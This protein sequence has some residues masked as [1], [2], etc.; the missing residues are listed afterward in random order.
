MSMRLRLPERHIQ[1]PEPALGVPIGLAIGGAA[2]LAF[3]VILSV[4]LGVDLSPW[5]WYLARG[6]GITLYLLSAFLLLSGL[7][8]RAHAFR[9]SIST[10]LLA[11][12]HA[13][14]WQLFLGFLV[15]HVGALMIDPTMTFAA[16]TLL[17]PFRSPA[18]EPWT[19]FGI[20]AA[21]LMIVTGSSSLL[22]R[23]IGYRGWKALHWLS[24]PAFATGLAHGIGA[25][26]DTTQ[27]PVFAMYVVTGGWV[28]AIGMLRAVRHNDRNNARINRLPDPANVRPEAP[29]AR[30]D[31]RR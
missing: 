16:G 6:S 1:R 28:I 9:G 17:V 14:A 5:T 18:A 8:G 2:G 23:L 20:I 27:W 25:G 21:E 31:Y 3:A 10:G 7:G 11:S 19:G 13:Y 12:L 22:R 24:L 15:L 29:R 4:S 26:T 30:P